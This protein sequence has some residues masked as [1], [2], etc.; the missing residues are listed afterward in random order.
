MQVDEGL[1]CWYH[2]CI[3]KRKSYIHP[4]FHSGSSDGL[5]DEP[6]LPPWSHTNNMANTVSWPSTWTPL[7]TDSSPWPHRLYIW[8]YFR[9]LSSQISSII[10]VKTSV[11]RRSTIIF[12]SCLQGRNKHQ[13]DVQHYITASQ[14]LWGKRPALNIQIIC[15][16]VSV[17]SLAVCRPSCFCIL[18]HFGCCPANSAGITLTERM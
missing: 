9:F 6:A 16:C 15:S 5:I 1:S 3:Y 4:I 12:N 2:E 13:L 17:C 10:T 18:K 8:I 11:Q 7:F 14:P